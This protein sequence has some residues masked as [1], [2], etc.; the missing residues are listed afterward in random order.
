MRAWWAGLLV[1]GVCVTIPVPY[2]TV[3]RIR[4][5]AGWAP[6]GVSLV[7]SPSAAALETPALQLL[8][9]MGQGKGR[10][11][12]VLWCAAAYSQTPTLACNRACYPAVSGLPPSSLLP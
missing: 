6:P 1:W 10:I 4:R 8:R 9:A 7:S 3:V 5:G 11:G 12:V 2:L